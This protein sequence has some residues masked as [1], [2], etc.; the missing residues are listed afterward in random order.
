MQPGRFMRLTPAL[1]HLGGVQQQ[2]HV[3]VLQVGQK[4]RLCHLGAQPLNTAGL[5]PRNRRA[6]E[7][8]Y[9]RTRGCGFG[10]VGFQRGQATLKLFGVRRGRRR[11]RD[12][13]R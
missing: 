6:A 12:A 5:P 11:G 7:R 9:R 10:K 13:H 4:M 1:A 3:V 8:L 2:G